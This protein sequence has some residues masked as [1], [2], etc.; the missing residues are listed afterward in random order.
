[1]ATSLGPDVD[2]FLTITEWPR[3]G[4]W[5][6]FRLYA[7]CNVS[8]G[9][10]AGQQNT[11]S[12]YFLTMYQDSTNNVYVWIGKATNSTS[13][14]I[15]GT[16]DLTAGVVQAVSNGDSF[17]LR[18]NGTS[19]TSYHKPVAGSWTQLET[20]TDA[21][22]SGAGFTGFYMP[23]N[24][25]NNTATN[26]GYYDDFGAGPNTGGTFPEAPIV[27]SFTRADAATLGSNWE[28][29]ADQN[30]ADPYHTDAASI[31]SNRAT[32]TRFTLTGADYY[33]YAWAGP[34]SSP[35]P[36]TPPQ[37][38][39]PNP[40]PCC[41]SGGS[42]PSGTNPGPVITPKDP[43]WTPRCT[44]GGGEPT[45]ATITNAE[46]WSALPNK[47]PCFR[48]TLHLAKY[49]ASDGTTIY[50]WSQRPMADAGAWSEGRILSFGDIKK[51][52]TDQDGNFQIAKLSITLTDEDG[53]FRGLLATTGTKYFFGRE[54]ELE[55][56]SEAG[57][58]ASLDWR[59]LF[60]G[61][62]TSIQPAS[63]RQIVVELSDVVGS[64]FSG[65]NL[66]KMIGLYLGDEHTALPE[67][68]RKLIYPIVVGEISDHGSL[69]TDPSSGLD[70]SAEKGMLPVIDTGDYDIT[71]GAATP[72]L[73][74]PPA[75]VV[76]TLVGPGSGPYTYSYAVTSGNAYGESGPSAVVTVTG[77]PKIFDATTYVDLTWDPVVGATFH[78]VLGRVNPLAT[79]LDGMNNGGT[80]VS[81][82]TQ[83]FDDD[84]HDIEKANPPFGGA[85]TSNDIWGRLLVSLGYTDV[86]DIFWSD[87]NPGGEP[88]RVLADPSLDGVEY[89][90]SASAS[91]PHPD[92]WLEL[93]HPTT[94]AVIR[95]TYIYVRGHRLA[96]HRDGSVTIAVN[97]CGMEDV[98][99]G[100]GVMIDQAFYAGMWFLNEHIL[101]DAGTGSTG[102]NLGP[103]ETYANGD[104]QVWTQRWIDMQAVTIARIGGL[105]YLA[106]W[107]VHE[108]ISVR[109]WVRRFCLTF[110]CRLVVN[111][112]GQIYP[113]L[114][115]DL[116]STGVGRRYRERVEQ[117]DL[118]D[119]R[120]AHDETENR[121]SYVLDWDPDAQA[122]RY[123]ESLVIEDATSIAAHV[124]G[125][126]VGTPNPAGVHQGPLQELWYT[127]DEETATDSRER[128]LTRNAYAPC[129]ATHAQDLLGLETEIGDPVRLTHRDGIGSSGFVDAEFVVLEHIVRASYGQ[130]G[131][132]MVGIR[133]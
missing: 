37:S 68:S 80:Y 94:G 113:V 124:P 122:F 106:A 31:S 24:F 19:I 104:P 87:L 83:Y 118:I 98:G 26:P 53:L 7:R 63:Q 109:E 99:D 100:S 22:Y 28:Q 3:W 133:R 65:L 102:G 6:N 20:V 97:G 12:G 58:A 84:D 82:E 33:A 59:V 44:G 93:T 49:P 21:T 90:T 9:V 127:R 72:T 10:I 38:I 40:Q 46:D 34:S 129:Y 2:V 70:V 103:L 42:T 11:W 56:L 91:W 88:K 120:L 62:V 131:T 43:S 14:G 77:C 18:V 64:N 116:A 76:A 74:A 71:G 130:I 17:G 110:D 8:G 55:V 61:R 1:M 48:F 41:G 114:I 50:R 95:A 69:G 4:A 81:P 35:A 29:F 119:V 73:L 125:G 107:T 89:L 126:V 47:V 66:D 5:D 101:K 16:T 108:P 36:T 96:A 51:S 123:T 85:P 45:G 115:D 52:G 13:A 23:G 117:V 32:N 128:R 132:E 25:L 111:T 67:A 112:H 54:G 86:H 60:R 30:A 39:I 79:W 121:I 75:N 15:S 78:R 27:D 105:G 57:R 92:P